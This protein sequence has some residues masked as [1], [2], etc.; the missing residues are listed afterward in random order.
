MP[1][2]SRVGA[3]GAFHTAAQLA[4]RG[5]D[6]AL[7]YGNTPRT[8]IVAQHG[9]S[10]RT[11]AVQC[12]TSTGKEDFMLNK[13]CE[14][15]SPPG[16]DEWFVLLNLYDPT[17]RPDFYVIPRN[18]ASAYVYL[19]HRVWLRGEKKDG[20]RRM[21]NSMRKVELEI[22]APYRE[23]WDLLECSAE[24]APC[25]LP[26]PVSQWM[27]QVGLPEGHPGIVE[28]NDGVEIPVTKKWLS[29]TPPPTA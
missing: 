5:W 3:A 1:D 18:V 21:D 14:S 15:P 17:D 11:V 7:T 29:L 2:R 28:A 9:E 20:T 6:A 23:R 16:R 13:G 4:Q 25:W 10:K 22:A 24:T 8:D 26:D 19:D 27:S 12:K